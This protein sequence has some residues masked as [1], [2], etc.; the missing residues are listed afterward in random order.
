MVIDTSALVCILGNEADAGR[1]EDAINADPVRM[2]SAASILETFIVLQ[3][4]FGDTAGR[5]LD[6]LIHQLP[7]DVRSVDRDQLEWAR[8]A[9][10]VYGRGRHPAS[11]N[12]GDCFSYGLA[13]ATGESLLFKGSD[14]GRTDLRCVL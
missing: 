2:M 10:R 5:E 14:F 9:F 4:K 8:F 7:I 3:S 1:Y 6:L 12:F 11:L 13:K